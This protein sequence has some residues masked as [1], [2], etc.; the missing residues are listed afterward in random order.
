ML[1]LLGNCMKYKIN[2]SREN[3]EKVIDN[4]IVGYKAYRN[5]N[6]LKDHFIHGMTFEEVAE[7]HDM[8]VRQ[9]KDISYNGYSIISSH[10]RVEE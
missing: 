3:I 9:V 8:S 4:Y 10:L 6:I 5:R 1:V 2:D 7:K